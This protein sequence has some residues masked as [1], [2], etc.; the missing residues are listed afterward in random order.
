[1]KLDD[2][3]GFFVFF[4]VTKNCQQIQNNVAGV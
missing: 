1:M 4:V 2:G 3:M